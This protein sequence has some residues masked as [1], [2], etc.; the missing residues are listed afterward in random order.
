MYPSQKNN[1]FVEFSDLSAFFISFCHS[2]PLRGGL[3]LAGEV[4]CK[5]YNEEILCLTMAP[6]FE[7]IS[8]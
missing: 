4:Y 8:N 2:R 6:L 1:N 5:I 3:D 7:H